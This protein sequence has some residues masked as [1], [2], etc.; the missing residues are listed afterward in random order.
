MRGHKATLLGVAAAIVTVAAIPWV[1]FVASWYFHWCL[2]MMGLA[3]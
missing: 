1:M 2:Q 3:P